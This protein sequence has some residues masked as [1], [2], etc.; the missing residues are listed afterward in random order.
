[1]RQGSTAA[2][3]LKLTDPR[4]ACASMLRRAAAPCAWPSDRSTSLPH[5]PS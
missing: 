5:L 3:P 1:L 2:P 4:Y